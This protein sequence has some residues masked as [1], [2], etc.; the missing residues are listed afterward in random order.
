MHLQS[1]HNS[2][3]IGCVFSMVKMIHFVTKGQ[4]ISWCKSDKLYCKTDDSVANRT[5]SAAKAMNS[6][7][8]RTNLIA[9]PYKIDCSIKV[10]LQ[11]DQQ[12]SKEALYN[13]IM[14]FIILNWF[15]L[16]PYSIPVILLYRILLIQS[17][18]CS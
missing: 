15:F 7:A 10:V 2:H 6:F 4:L 11:K 14:T 1:Q 12:C 5:E 9:K 17:P 8:N 3:I 16:I 18:L 13:H